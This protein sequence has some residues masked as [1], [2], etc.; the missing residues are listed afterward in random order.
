LNYFFWEKP[1][2]L[3]AHRSSVLQLSHRFWQSDY[4]YDKN[5]ADHGDLHEMFEYVH[6]NPA[7]RTLV[8]QFQE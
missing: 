1:V 5:I 3:L 8:N 4:G 6:Q 2:G 7:W